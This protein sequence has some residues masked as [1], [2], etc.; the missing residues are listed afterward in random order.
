M[1]GFPTFPTIQILALAYLGGQFE[2]RIHIIQNEL[3]GDG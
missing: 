1:D 3:T 2:L